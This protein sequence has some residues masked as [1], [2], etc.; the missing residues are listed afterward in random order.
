[1]NLIQRIFGAKKKATSEA[2]SKEPLAETGYLPLD[3]LLLQ[4][5]PSIRAK[6]IDRNINQT[7]NRIR[8]PPVS[9]RLVTETVEALI[10]DGEISDADKLL[11]SCL[12]AL[13]TLNERVDLHELYGDIKATY[14]IQEFSKGEDYR[15][16]ANLALELG[17]SERAVELYCK[18]GDNQTAVNTALK[19]GL[20][21]K[22]EEIGLR[23]IAQIE[24]GGKSSDHLLR[25][26]AEIADKIGKPEKS[27]ELW[28]RVLNEQEL[29]QGDFGWAATIA[30]EKIKSPEVAAD[31]RRREI[32]SLVRKGNFYHAGEV[33]ED[34]GLIEESKRYYLE[35]LNDPETALYYQAICA[36]K[37]GNADLAIRLNSELNQF[38]TAVDIASSAGKSWEEIEKLFY[39]KLEYCEKKGDL[40]GTIETAR[41]LGLND[42]LGFYGSIYRGF[43]GDN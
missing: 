19:Y 1:M 26:A 20:N 32:E 6:M 39:G 9:K 38:D 43:T 27:K 36:S 11:K 17:L 33:A 24:N 42:E 29:P 25:Y 28:Q 5:E 16:A 23:Y 22:A 35:V 14:N 4:L 21:Q 40:E 13:F 3:N 15:S 10:K 34:A 7:K 41:Y 12:S 30:E 18:A 8:V 31:I 37:V 2:T